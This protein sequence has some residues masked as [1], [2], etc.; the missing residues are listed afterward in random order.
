VLFVLRGGAYL[1][2]HRDRKHTR[3]SSVKYLINIEVLITSQLLLYQV[4]QNAGDPI[5]REYIS[6]TDLKNVS[7]VALAPNAKY[8]AIDADCTLRLYERRQL[9]D[10]MKL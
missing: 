1:P 5:A 9:L 8:I 3:G 2:S 6:L 7:R 4:P 10:S